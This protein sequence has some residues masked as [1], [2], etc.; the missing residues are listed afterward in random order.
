MLY[1]QLTEKARLTPRVRYWKKHGWRSEV[2]VYD[3]GLG[4]IIIGDFVKTREEA[5]R[6]ATQAAYDA[7]PRYR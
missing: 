5:E 1:P 2:L 7:V 6:L 4:D 3:G